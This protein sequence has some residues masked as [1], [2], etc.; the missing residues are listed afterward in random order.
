MHDDVRRQIA[1][2]GS[3]YHNYTSIAPPPFFFYVI[4]FLGTCFRTTC[5]LSL[6]RSGQAGL[7]CLP[8]DGA[9]LPTDQ[10]ARVRLQARSDQAPFRRHRAPFRPLHQQGAPPRQGGQP[11]ALLRPRQT[12]PRLAPVGGTQ[13]PPLTASGSPQARRSG[14]DDGG[15]GR[16]V[17]L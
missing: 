9:D 13:R 17:S 8:V 7:L 5:S 3:K 11:P 10:T 15:G 2:T 16:C 6:S 1:L 4:F 14:S 12:S